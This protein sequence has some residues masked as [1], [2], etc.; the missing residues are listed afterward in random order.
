MNGKKNVFDRAHKRVTTILAPPIIYVIIYLL[1]AKLGHWYST[2]DTSC[3]PKE[4]MG[5]YVR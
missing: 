5:A 1:L 3:P 4:P 2:C